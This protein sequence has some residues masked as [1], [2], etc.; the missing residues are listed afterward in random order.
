METSISFVGGEKESRECPKC[1]NKENWK[2]GIR[3]TK[4]GLVQRFLCRECG[5][6]FSQSIILSINSSNSGNCQVC[7]TLA[8]AKNLE[9]TTEIKT[10]VGEKTTNKNEADKEF[11]SYLRRQAYSEA[12]INTRAKLIRQIQKNGVNLLTPKAVKQFIADQ[13]WSNGHKQVVVQAYNSFTQMMHIQW[14]PPRYRHIK[15]LPFLPT[16]HE[17][18]ALITGTSKRISTSLLLLKETGMRIGEAWN[19]RWIDIDQKRK[20]IRCKAEKHGYPREFKV[21]TNLL[22]MLDA[23]PKKNK[24]VFTK[25]SL[26]S[27]RWNFIKQRRRLAEKLKNPRLKQIKFH[28]FRHWYASR[29][30]AKTSSIVHVQQRLGHRNINSTMVYTHLIKTEGDKYYSATAKTTEEAKRLLENGFSFVCITPED[31]MLFRKPK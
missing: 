4:N 13:N 21:S 7:A 17:I 16:A 26:N 10:V 20:T 18:N 24:H 8:D 31:I 27:H 3:K 15:S 28:T 29:E 5:Y 11:K 19:L 14:N 1:H 30:Y 2:D 12:T 9:H 6:R 22:A 25:T 23:L